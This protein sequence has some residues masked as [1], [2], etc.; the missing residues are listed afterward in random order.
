MLNGDRESGG[1]WERKE[2]KMEGGWEGARE[3]RGRVD[4]GGERE[5]M[6]AGWF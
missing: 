6:G 1:K 2:V 5:P 3:E 4:G